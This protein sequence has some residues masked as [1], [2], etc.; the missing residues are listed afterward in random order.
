MAV[1]VRLYVL[2]SCSGAIWALARAVAN[3]TY[4]LC[5]RRRRPRQKTEEE[6]KR[7]DSEVT[8]KNR[9]APKVYCTHTHS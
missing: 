6:E 7:N 9:Y 3:S 8:Q 4:A 5:C 1:P 2:H